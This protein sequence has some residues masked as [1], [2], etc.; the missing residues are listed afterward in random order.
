M[1]IP[2]WRYVN[3]SLDAAGI[4]AS[5]LLGADNPDFSDELSQSTAAIVSG[6]SFNKCYGSLFASIPTG[7]YSSNFTVLEYS[8]TRFSSDSNIQ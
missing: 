8:N 7:D 4:L 1:I 6:E 5:I 3:V 2:R